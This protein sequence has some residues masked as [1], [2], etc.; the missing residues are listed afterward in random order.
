MQDEAAVLGDYVEE[1]QDDHKAAVQSTLNSA[2]GDRTSLRD[3]SSVDLSSKKSGKK[4]CIG[5]S[6][7]SKAIKKGA[8]RAKKGK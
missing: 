8:S 7:A 1:N 5:K 6:S 4:S 2:R 3:S